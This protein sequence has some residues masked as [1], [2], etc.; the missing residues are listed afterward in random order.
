MQSQALRTTVIGSYFPDFLDLK[1]D[2]LHLE[3]ASRENAELEAI[4]RWRSGWTW[5]WGSSM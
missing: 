3:M 5:R 2:E 1:V 4:G